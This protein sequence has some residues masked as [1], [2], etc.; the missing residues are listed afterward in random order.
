MTILP[1]REGGDAEMTIKKTGR[2]VIPVLSI[3]KVS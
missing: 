3:T 2:S 1:M